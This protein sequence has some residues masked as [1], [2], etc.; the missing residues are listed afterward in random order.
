MERYG[1]MVPGNP[2]NLDEL[3]EDLARQIA[4]A[5]ALLE[6]MTPE[7][8]AKL[9]ELSEALLE[10]DLDMRMELEWLAANW[11]RVNWEPVPGHD[12][13]A[14]TGRR[15]DQPAVRPRA[16]W[17]SSWPEPPARARWPK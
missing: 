13:V 1:D 9:A 7:Q 14:R 8:R 3:L 15:S 17:S 12:A 2:A 11:Q 16:T 4:T 6:S 10:D 5:R